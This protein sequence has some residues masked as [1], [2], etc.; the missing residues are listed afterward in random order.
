[1]DL[2]RATRDLH[3]G[4]TERP[5]ARFGPE[6]TDGTAEPLDV[7]AVEEPLE[8]RI[9]GEPIAITM[10]TP[11]QDERLAVGFLFAEGLIGGPGDLASVAHCGRPGE[12]GYGNVI[13]VKAAPGV[14]VELLR[15]LDSRRFGIVTAACGVCGRRTI[16]DLLK[17]CQPLPAAGAAL[18]K[19]QV[20]RAVD[21]LRALQPNF[22]RTGGIH[23][24]ALFAQDGG[25]LTAQEDIGRHNAV[26][27]AIG[28]LLYRGLGGAGAS[29]PGPAL[30]VVSGRASF[31][32]VQKACMARVPVVAS[33]SAASSLAI[34]LAAAAGLTLIGFVRAG[35]LNVYTHPE[36]L[37]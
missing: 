12:E 34:D 32:I 23:A 19:A 22:A 24:A 13:E 7:V 5:L 9:D 20:V 28:D 3:A 36:R 11:G 14:G 37:S 26:D 6:R 4:T 25:L 17:R 27:K 29:G 2:H 31:E 8:I 30:L 16:D 21:S 10:R 18:A 1:M 15:V 35:S 33:V